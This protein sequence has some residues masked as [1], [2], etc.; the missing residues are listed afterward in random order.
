MST[1]RC[2]LTALLLLA[3]LVPGA[4]ASLALPAASPVAATAQAASGAM[5]I[6]ENAGQWPEAARFQVWKSPLGPGTTWLAED[7]IWLVVSSDDKVTRWQGDKATVRSD[8]VT[9][10]PGHPVTLSSQ[11]ALKLTFPGSNPDVRIEPFDPMTTTV[12]YFIGGDPERWRPAVPVWGGARYA[13][14]YPGVDLVLGSPVGSWHLDVRPD[15]QTRAVRLRVEGADQALLTQGVLHLSTLT[16]AIDLQLPTSQTALEI[17]VVTTGD[18][19]AIF[20]L[21]PPSPDPNTRAPGMEP[22]DLR[23]ST[24]LGGGSV[25][26]GLANAVDGSGN[27]YVTGITASSNFP[28]TPGAF[29]PSANFWYDAFVAKLNPSGASLVYA[30]FLGGNNRDFGWAIAVDSSAS[31][32]L[33]GHTCSNDFPATPGALDTSANGEGDAFVA[34]L[35]PTGSRLIYATYLGGSTYDAGEGIALDE[36]GSAYVTGFTGSGDFPATPGAFDTSSSGND[37]FVAKLNPGGSALDYA[38]FLGGSEWDVTHAIAVDGAGRAHMPGF[39]ASS[40]F[41]ATQG[42]F[43]PSYNG[44]GDAFVA[45]LNASGSGLV[46][47]TFL[48]GG[49]HDVALGIAVGESGHAF[50]SGYTTSA[51][52]PTT[53]GAFDTG[54]HVG[55]CGDGPCPDAFVA[56]L[57]PAGGR[58]S[59]ASYVGGGSADASTGVA[60]DGNGNAYLTGL[61][62]SGDFPTTA[63]S[64]DGDYN[65][66][67]CPNWPYEWWCGDAF[68][69][70]L[71][72]QGTQLLYGAFLGGSGDDVGQAIAV[73]QA[74]TAYIAGLTASSNFPTSPGSF[75]ANYNGGKDAFMA[76]LDAYLPLVS[77]PWTGQPRTIDGNFEEWGQ[78]S[79][80]ILSRDTAKY[81]AS[82][83][84]SIPAPSLADSSAELRALWTGFNLYLAI[85]VRDDMIVSDSPDVWRDDELELAFV[86]AWDGL[87]AGGDTHQYTVNADGRVTDFGVPGAPVPVQ[88]VAVEA[89]GGWSVEMRIPAAH[90]FGTNMPLTAGKTIAFDLGLHDDDDGDNWDSHMIWAGDSTNFQAGGLLRLESIIAPTPAPTQTPTA[91]PTA[92]A[93]PSPTATPTATAT[94]TPSPTAT[95]TRTATATATP[96]ATATST[97]TGAPANTATPTATPVVRYRYLPLIIRQ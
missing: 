54:F 56:R 63:G 28:T 74:G 14:L 90:L 31:A 94:P 57:D 40:D 18:A 51:D 16:G 25:D 75:D 26:Q 3:L 2:L 79:P 50:V 1:Q 45:S 62:L 32:Y 6:V 76:K 27:A 73:D 65:G 22:G 5:L 67:T 96:T 59:Y 88:A 55:R 64:Y 53:P 48:G 47:A 21:L 4:V 42:A 7:A 33:S 61:T 12:S 86:G 71:N 10:S 72:P 70:K 49:G 58:L 89:P 30:T 46:Y 41:P 24:F 36:S 8:S 78:W 35:D 87:P 85:Y 34:K 91:T 95:P 43:D 29:D 82:L 68:L 39:T 44:D 97:P 93:T 15:A 77:A 69:L 11:I 37:A 19:P 80:L 92:T 52:F 84:A 66:E 20:H 60:V 17:E 23:Y 83:P 81:V 9:L 38:T 13:D